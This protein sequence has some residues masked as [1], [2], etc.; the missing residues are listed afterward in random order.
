MDLSILVSGVARH[1]CFVIRCHQPLKKY[2]VLSDVH[3][4]W[5]LADW[6]WLEKNLKGFSDVFVCVV[7]ND[8]QTTGWTSSKQ[9]SYCQ[10]PT[11]SNSDW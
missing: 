5:W 6:G 9:K 3:S 4:R 1:T 11:A 2:Q 7:N 8:W 10:T